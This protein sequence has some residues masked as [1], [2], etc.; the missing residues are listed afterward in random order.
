LADGAAQR[1]G[2]EANANGTPAGPWLGRSVAVVR[3]TP[4][5]AL[6]AAR[7]E[8]SVSQCL[9]G[10]SKSIRRRNTKS[11]AKPDTTATPTVR[12]RPDTT[13][14]TNSPARAGHNRRHAQAHSR[15]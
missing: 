14:D 2:S 13:R 12:L 4:R 15:S 8:R 5:P 7:V 3:L 6:R 10:L 1:R 9:R 11:C